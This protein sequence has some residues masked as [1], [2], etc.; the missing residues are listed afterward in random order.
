WEFMLGIACVPAFLVAA[1][2]VKFPDTPRWY[3]LTGQRERGI[4]ALQRIEPPER[5]DERL[6]EIDDDLAGSGGKIRELFS[7]R[8]ARATFFVIGFGFL[9]QIT[10]INAIIY[11]APIIFHTIGLPITKAIL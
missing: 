8:F 1:A 2:L 5:V 4:D 9:V 6:S 11:Y 3:L 10:G 7:K